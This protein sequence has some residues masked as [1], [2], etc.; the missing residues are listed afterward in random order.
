MCHIGKE[1][2]RASEMQCS[3]HQNCLSGHMPHMHL[4]RSWIPVRRKEC[5]VEAMHLEPPG[6]YNFEA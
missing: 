3:M 4:S 5:T 2:L 6:T 1:S